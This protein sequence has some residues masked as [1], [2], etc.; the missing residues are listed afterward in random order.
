[1]DGIE[2]VVRGNFD[3]YSPGDVISDKAK[4]D[5]ILA[6]PHEHDVIKRKIASDTPIIKS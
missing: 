6:G 2:L 4:I 1:M 5:E 3:G